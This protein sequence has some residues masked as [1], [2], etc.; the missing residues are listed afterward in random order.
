MTQITYEPAITALLVVAPYNDF[1][2]DGGKLWKFAKET[3]E[4]VCGV[5]N[6]IKVIE[7][8][9]AA[10]LRVFIAPHHRWREGDFTT[11]KYVAPIQASGGRRQVFADGTWGGQFHPAFKPKPG[12]IV[13]QE[14]WCSSGFNST[15]LDQ[16]L[17][18]HGER[19]G[20][21]IMTDREGSECHNYRTFVLRAQGAARAHLG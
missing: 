7:A 3:A 10:G 8:S 14:H 4:G 16:L 15:D 18:R 1:I 5:P 17:Q 21:G 19:V 9:R 6:M 20:P 11:W 12:D 2:S 13:A